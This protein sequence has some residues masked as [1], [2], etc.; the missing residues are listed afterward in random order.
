MDIKV[1]ADLKQ[2]ITTTIHDEVAPILVSLDGMDARFDGVDI[3]L[4]GIDTRLDGIDT[5]LDKIDDRL[6]ENDTKQNEILNAI[7]EIQDAQGKAIYMHATF[8]DDHE[9]RI[10]KLEK[11]AV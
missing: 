5:R 6:D 3:R 7:G 9:R 1:L 2:F 4:D 11:Y 8:L 10:L